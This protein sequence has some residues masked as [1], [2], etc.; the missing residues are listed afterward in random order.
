MIYADIFSNYQ[1]AVDAFKNASYSRAISSFLPVVTTLVGIY[2]V[3][4][5]WAGLRG[6]VQDWG[7]DLVARVVKICLII[8]IGF[9][10]AG[11]GMYVVDPVLNI[12]ADLT[13]IVTG[14][15]AE[16]V[17]GPAILD[18]QFDKAIDLGKAAMEKGSLFS[19]NGLAFYL[20]ALIFYVSGLI[21]TVY[22]AYLMLLSK[23]MLAILVGFGPIFIGCLI[24]D[25][26]KR[27]FDAWVGLIVN[28]I[29]VFVFAVAAVSMTFVAFQNYLSKLTPESGLG[30]ALGLLVMAII[31]ILIIMGVTHMASSLAGGSPVG[32]GFGNWAVAAATGGATRFLGRGAKAGAGMGARVGARAAKKGAGAAA[33][34]ATRR[35]RTNSVKSG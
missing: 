20:T 24:F 29:M 17:A 7:N 4:Y 13:S 2:F 9:S 22:A 3:L 8:G 16:Q 5:S 32:N 14:K 11:Y 6:Q 31:D 33:A 27:F 23:G 28:Y 35:F 21:M 25:V 10:T 30:A 12:P 15:T 1:S 19:E 18:D 34:L 26:T